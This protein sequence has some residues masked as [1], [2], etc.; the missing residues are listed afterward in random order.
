MFVIEYA[1]TIYDDLDTM[2]P[3]DRRR[4]RDTI[5]EQLT[6]EPNVETRN[7][8]P[9]GYIP[10]EWDISNELWELRVGEFR[11][12]Y[13]F[14]LNEKIVMVHGVREQHLTRRQETSYENAGS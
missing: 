9:L 4:V 6:Y 8:K 12:F 2:R 11:V 3:F 13:E 5:I 14:E 7:R 10:T 1:D